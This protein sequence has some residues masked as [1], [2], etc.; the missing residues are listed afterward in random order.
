MA[1]TDLNKLLLALAVV[2]SVVGAVDAAVGGQP[3]LVVVFGLGAV[4]QLALLVRLQVRRP[5]VPVRADLVSWLRDRAATE[6]E[7][8][9]LVADRC[10]AA[11][12]ADLDR[13]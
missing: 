8:I 3:D 4:L 1:P 12:R 2:V 7:P 11:C 10:L 13:A 6:G 5:A 9:G